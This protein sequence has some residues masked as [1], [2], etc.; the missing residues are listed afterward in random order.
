[1]SVFILRSCGSSK[2]IGASVFRKSS[3]A[4]SYCLSG[5]EVEVFGSNEIDGPKA[6]I[7][8]NGKNH[9]K[10]IRLELSQSKKICPFPFIDQK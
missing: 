7:M 10:A 8:C 4:S 1:L 3:G 5:N 6:F 2:E 9:P